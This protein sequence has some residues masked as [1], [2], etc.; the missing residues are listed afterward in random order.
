MT[1]PDEGWAQRTVFVDC[2]AGV[3][4]FELPLP[5]GLKLL[6]GHNGRSQ[7]SNAVPLSI[8]KGMISCYGKQYSCATECSIGH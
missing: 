7:L 2:L 5:L 3:T 8:H 1:N 4:F 6:H